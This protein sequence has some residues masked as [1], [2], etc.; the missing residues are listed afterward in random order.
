[1]GPDIANVWVAFAAL[2]VLGIGYAVSATVYISRIEL[3]CNRSIDT[4]KELMV[5]I[6]EREISKESK[7]RHDLTNHIQVQITTLDNDYRGLQAKMSEM[8]HKGDL[9]ATESRI[10][11]SIDKLENRLESMFTERRV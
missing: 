3:S 2:V 10:S 7:A 9:L 4:S 8:V 6:I 11:A 5:T 1:M